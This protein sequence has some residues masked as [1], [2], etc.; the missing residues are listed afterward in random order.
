MEELSEG[1][2]ELKRPHLASVGREV[3]GLVK[4][5]CPRKTRQ[6]KQELE[7]GWWSNLTEAG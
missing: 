3:L 5:C 7:I 4:T 2:E 1:L 6:V